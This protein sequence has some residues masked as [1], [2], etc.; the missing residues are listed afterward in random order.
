MTI[1]KPELGDVQ[2]APTVPSPPPIVARG[3]TNYPAAGTP[4]KA[5]VGKNVVYGKVHAL[6]GKRHEVQVSAFALLVDID[7]LG[8]LSTPWFLRYADWTIELNP[9]D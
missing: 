8:K 1:F 6:D 3:A 2:L 4:V 9:K 5:T 7:G